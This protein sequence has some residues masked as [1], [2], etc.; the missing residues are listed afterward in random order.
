LLLKATFVKVLGS[1]PAATTA[2]EPLRDDVDGISQLPES[3]GDPQR[4]HET[5]SVSGTDQMLKLGI[6]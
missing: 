1:Y 6:A 2:F 5:S 4:T 3:G